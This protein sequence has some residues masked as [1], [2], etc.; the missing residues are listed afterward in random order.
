MACKHNTV[1]IFLFL[2]FLVLSPIS[3]EGPYR[4]WNLRL[5][6]EKFYAPVTFDIVP[7]SAPIP[8]SAPSKRHNDHEESENLVGPSNNGG[9]VH[10]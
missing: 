5:H 7:K 9:G 3:N 6:K 4:A 2:L 10:P 8:P 1:T